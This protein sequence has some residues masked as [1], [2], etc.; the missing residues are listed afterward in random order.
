VAAPGATTIEGLGVPP[1]R[2]PWERYGFV[3]LLAAVVVAA[4]AD[5]FGQSPTTST[6]SAGAATLEVQAPERLRGGLYF[7]VRLTI[8]ARRAVE[9]PTLV[10]DRGWFEQMSVNSIVPE[11]AGERSAADGRVVLEYGRI[12]AGATFVGYVYFQVNPTNVGKR[13]ADVELLDGSRLLA[14][15]HRTIVVFP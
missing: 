13:R 10:L 2:R 4:L 5:V 8:R 3:L 6:A 9:R 7:Q 15:V 1:R 12:A 14:T 11:P